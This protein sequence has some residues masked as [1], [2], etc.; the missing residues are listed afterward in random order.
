MQLGRRK[1]RKSCILLAKDWIKCF[2][3]KK[4]GQIK[5]G[6]LYRSRATGESCT[7]YPAAPRPPQG[8]ARPAGRRRAPPYAGPAAPTRA[9]A[10]PPSRS[11]GVLA[12]VSV[13]GRVAGRGLRC[14]TESLIVNSSSGTRAGQSSAR[15]P[16][17]ERRTSTMTPLT[18]ST[19]ELMP[20]TCCDVWRAEDELRT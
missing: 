18:R 13:E 16:A 15:S 3:D 7:P 4:P 14:D 20:I 12:A 11:R 5:R 19:L 17:K 2:P 9:P 8:T 1:F 6:N 10:L